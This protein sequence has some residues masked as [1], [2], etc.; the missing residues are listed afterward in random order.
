M[1]HAWKRSPRA[2]RQGQPPTQSHPEKTWTPP[3][4][5]DACGYDRVQRTRDQVTYLRGVV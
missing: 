4:P 1:T 5:C 3:G 2:Q